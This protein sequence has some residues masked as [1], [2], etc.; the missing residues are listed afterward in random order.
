LLTLG[1]LAGAFIA[2]GAL[3][4]VVV[5]GGIPGIKEVNLGLQKFIFGAVFPVGIM[6]VVIAGAE[7]FTGNT[8]SLM[9]AML[10]KKAKWFGRLEIGLC[11]IL[12]TSWDRSLLFFS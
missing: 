11:H 2:F 8:A 5:G 6:F 4:V 3:S 12:G 1:F 7:L 9:P 10:S